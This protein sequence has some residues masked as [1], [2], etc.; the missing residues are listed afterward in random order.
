[1]AWRCGGTKIA[2]NYGTLKIKK[3]SIQ[4]CSTHGNPVQAH[5]RPETCFHHR[6]AG[7]PPSHRRPRASG[8][9][10]GRATRNQSA[11]SLR[12]RPSEGTYPQATKRRP[13]RGSQQVSRAVSR[14]L[15]TEFSRADDR[16]VG[17]PAMPPEQE[18]H[19][20]AGEYHRYVSRMRYPPTFA[21]WLD[22][23]ERPAPPDFA[24]QL[25]ALADEPGCRSPLKRVI[26][27]R[28]QDDIGGYRADRQ[29]S[30]VGPNDLLWLPGAA[31]PRRKR[32]QRR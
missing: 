23:R 24:A 9:A 18:A 31:P 7:R 6:A 27:S 13:D 1:M 32:G 22:R 3:N 25:Q 16:R 26:W 28:R 21:E 4:S 2:L 30:L 17:L 19:P 12:P 29:T 15:P 11:G 10:I 8:A 5:D 14:P 20:L